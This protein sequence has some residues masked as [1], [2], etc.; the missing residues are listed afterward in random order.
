M[1]KLVI[2]SVLVSSM[3]FAKSG[4]EIAS[5]LGIEVT[6]HSA[7][8]WEEVF[9]DK[10][11][12][13][14]IGVTILTLQERQALKSYLLSESLGKV[15]NSLRTDQIVKKLKINPASK[16]SRQWARIFKSEKYLKRYGLNTLSKSQLEKVKEYLINN[17]ADM[18]KDESA[19]F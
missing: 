19:G 1:K 5:E 2:A 13:D 6:M 12:L 9:K 7:E 14:S 11:K 15:S 17:S 8:E 4:A 3:L 10:N 16:V 18:I